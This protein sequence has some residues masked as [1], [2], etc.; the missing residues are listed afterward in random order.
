MIF[1]FWVLSL[2]ILYFKGKG[3][4][5]NQLVQ[6]L[7]INE[8]DIGQ[9]LNIA[10][11]YNTSIAD[12]M[13]S[14]LNSI[15]SNK[16]QHPLIAQL[17][18]FPAIQSYGLDGSEKINNQ[19][20]N[21]N[22][23][24]IGSLLDV[25]LEIIDEISAALSLNLS[26]PLTGENHDFT[27]SYYTSKNGFLLLSPSVSI[28]DFH[29]SE[30][31]YGNPFWSIA[32]PDYNPKKETVIS[33]LYIDA[34]G[35]GLMISIS[36]P[37]YNNQTFKGVVSLD[38]GLH[39]LQGVLSSGNLSLNEHLFL[40]SKEGRIAASTNET[41][42]GNSLI[43]TKPSIFNHYLL[44]QYRDKYYVKS[45]L[46]NDKFY[47]IYELTLM[48]INGLIIKKTYNQAL[49]VSL[50]TMI[51]WLL[52]YLFS[53]LAYNKKLAQYDSLSKLYNRRTLEHLA[54]H[55]IKL[56]LKEKTTLSVLMIDIDNFK[57][58]NDKYGHHIGDIGIKHVATI[59]SQSVRKIDLV[60]R[61]GG[62]EFV[63]ILPKTNI[64]QAV[65]IAEKIRKSI[66]QSTFSDNHS[67]TV[68]IGLTECIASTKTTTFNDLCQQADLALYS[69]KED[70]RNHSVCYHLVDEKY[71]KRLH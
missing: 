24:G 45:K 60:G 1:T 21:A 48:E 7:I 25:E 61:Y 59:M 52:V 13:E 33:D 49:I 32:T 40:I 62:E 54:R 71:N 50:F 29:L 65:I 68:S 18:D 20:Y 12:Q 38:V 63:V 15:G 47:I 14:N 41:S 55:E 17:K 8:R 46:V 19:P 37:V 5:E 64:E 10:I 58:L 43:N 67:V 57:K 34:G 16:Y 36:T 53:S 69:A 23:T 44:L 22:L 4:V 27:W 28:K 3:D 2:T 6:S 51:F 9:L 11:A 30:Y 35:Q 26:T 31:Y 56:S 66:A 39:Y 70:G 42:L